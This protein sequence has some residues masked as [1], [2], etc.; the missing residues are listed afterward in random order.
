MSTL[1]PLVESLSAALQAGDESAFKALSTAQGWESGGDS[2][3]RLWR[4]G[5]KKKWSLAPT[6][7]GPRG[8]GD[9]YALAVELHEEG[10]GAVAVVQ[11]LFVPEGGEMKLEGVNNSELF[12]NRFLEGKVTALLRYKDLP[13]DADADAW[14]KAAPLDLAASLTGVDG[15]DDYVA[16]ATAPG[17]TPTFIE[18]KMLESMGRATVLYELAQEGNDF[19]EELAILLERTQE[20]WRPIGVAD[21][22]DIELLIG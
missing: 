19:P 16:R 2:A 18:S 14:G 22:P 8:E 17:I 21:Y 12:V 20:G 15:A 5:T 4:Q 10:R 1:I 7:A 9:R 11:L 13:G 3:Q 6:G